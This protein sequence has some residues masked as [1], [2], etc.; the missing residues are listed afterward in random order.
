M[1]A[2]LLLANILLTYIISLPQF[3]IFQSYSKTPW[4]KPGQ[5]LSFSAE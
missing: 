2:H 5:C 1:H 3:T 4:V